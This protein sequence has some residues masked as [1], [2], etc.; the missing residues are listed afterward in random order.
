[1]PASVRRQRSASAPC[2]RI[3]SIRA[4]RSVRWASRGQLARRRAVR[5]RAVVGEPGVRRL[6]EKVGG[7]GAGQ[8]PGDARREQP[9]LVVGEPGPGR[10]TDHRPGERQVERQPQSPAG[11]VGRPGDRVTATLGAQQPGLR[12]TGLVE[13]AGA[14]HAARGRERRDRDPQRIRREQVAPPEQEHEVPTAGSDARVGRGLPRR[15]RLGQRADPHR[16]AVV[17]LLVDRPQRRV[18]AWLVNGL[19]D[20][21]DVDRRGPGPANPPRQRTDSRSAGTGQTWASA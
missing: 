16:R 4:H 6:L 3:A 14:Q 2:A 20:H 19:D 7:A 13:A 10:A 9:V 17:P 21:H 18:Q 1:M 11:R 5:T 12:L 8:Q 15:L